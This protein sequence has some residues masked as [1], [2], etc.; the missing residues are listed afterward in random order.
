MA[1]LILATS[2]RKRKVNLDRHPKTSKSR[3]SG[4]RKSAVLV[5]IGLPDHFNNTMLIIKVNPTGIIS[6]AKF[7]PS[8]VVTRFRGGQASIREVCRKKEK[9]G[10]RRKILF[11]DV[12]GIQKAIGGKGEIR[13]EGS[14]RRLSTKVE[15]VKRWDIKG[16]HNGL[17]GREGDI[18]HLLKVSA[19]NV[20]NTL[21][22]EKVSIKLSPFARLELFEY[23]SAHNLHEVL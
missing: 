22:L 14:G 2:V 18:S 16:L 9:R 4:L 19:K 5:F 6:K 10:K 8:F 3:T 17:I 1:L 13:R 12:G 7:T 11:G 21:R 23:I 15:R 20:A